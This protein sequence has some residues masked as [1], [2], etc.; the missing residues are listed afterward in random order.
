MST[1]TDD[2]QPVEPFF[3]TEVDSPR[4]R[5]SSV[6]KILL[7][8][9]GFMLLGTLF[10][11]WLGTPTASQSIGQPLP[12]LDLQPLLNVESSL[13]LDEVRGKVT[14]L[15]FW[16]TW[17]PPCRL[18]FPEFVE[19][20]NKFAGH[21]QT[22]IVSVS[23]SG[24]PEYNVEEL[25]SETET[26]LNKIAPDMKTYSDPAAMTRSGLAMLLFDGTFAYPT[27]V[28]VDSDGNVA[29]VMQGYREGAMQKLETR[30][31]SMLN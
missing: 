31:K 29:D 3:S 18:E 21:P 22:L 15:H 4:R 10:L 8:F 23:C 16:G 24:G 11:V 14:V 2:R 20:A 27:T 17:C 6:L 19:L 9:G 1:Q 7:L 25:K 28:L 5:S 13:T 26:Y 12:T 30:I